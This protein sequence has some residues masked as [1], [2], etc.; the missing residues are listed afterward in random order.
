MIENIACMRDIVE[1]VSK[2]V[3][4]VVERDNKFRLETV[5]CFV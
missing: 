5:S 4:V 2:N 1:F 3:K